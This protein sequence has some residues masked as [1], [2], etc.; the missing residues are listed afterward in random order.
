MNLETFKEILRDLTTIAKVNH[1]KESLINFV[2]NNPSELWRLLVKSAIFFTEDEVDE[3]LSII[4]K[5]RVANT[6]ENF[7][8]LIR[9]KKTE[10]TENHINKILNYYNDFNNKK[11]YLDS[12]FSEILSKKDFFMNTE[13]K[14][15]K[16]LR[17]FKIAESFSYKPIL[18]AQAANMPDFRKKLITLYLEKAKGRIT[19]T[20]VVAGQLKKGDL[21]YQNLI[22]L[23]KVL[24]E[25]RYYYWSNLYID[26]FKPINL[27]GDY[28]FKKPDDIFRNIINYISIRNDYNFNENHLNSLIDSKKS[29]KRLNEILK[30]LTNTEIFVLYSAFFDK[31]NIG[32]KYYFSS[33]EKV[34]GITQISSKYNYLKNKVLE[35]FRT[36][37]YSSMEISLYRDIQAN[38][39]NINFFDIENYN[40]R[41]FIESMFKI[42]N[43]DFNEEILLKLAGEIELLKAEKQVLDKNIF[44]LN[45]TIRINE[46]AEEISKSVYCIAYDPQG[47]ENKFFIPKTKETKTF[48]EIL[49]D[50]IKNAVNGSGNSR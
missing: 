10:L 19:E 7:Y 26:I 28:D 3:I 33:N 35:E 47:K 44:I 32:R 45:S 21:T 6:A 5:N 49:S 12:L 17:F 23:E 22:L 1:Y 4:K 24:D 30:L 13:E 41:P 25:D 27:F 36:R 39:V 29:L 42:K 8:Y 43:F 50:G 11:D 40:E 34:L 15:R 9:V 20:E 31:K 2:K 37:R 46:I 48:A 18:M 14:T 38:L 16:V